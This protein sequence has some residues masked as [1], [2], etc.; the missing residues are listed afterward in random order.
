MPAWIEVCRIAGRG[1]AVPELLAVDYFESLRKVLQVPISEAL[2]VAPS[3]SRAIV[4][5]S[6]FAV[7]SNQSRLAGSILNLDAL[8]GD[9]D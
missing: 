8:E 7:A 6:L 1:P 2:G 4:V 3:E 9:S 5:F